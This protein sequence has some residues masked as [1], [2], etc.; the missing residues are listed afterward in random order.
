MLAINTFVMQDSCSVSHRDHT[1]SHT[2][3]NNVIIIRSIQIA[4]L[5]I[6]NNRILNLS[7]HCRSDP[8]RDQKSQWIRDDI[9][10]IIESA[11]YV[12]MHDHTIIHM[13]M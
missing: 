1:P 9:I 6:N 2:H 10:L 12:S 4:S 8:D 13:Y 5:V 11:A 7:G 3:N